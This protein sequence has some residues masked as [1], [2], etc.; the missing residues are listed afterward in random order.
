MLTSRLMEFIETHARSLINA[1]MQDIMTNERTSSFRLVPVSELEPRIAA[2]YL[3]L[4]KWVGSPK[5]EAVQ[6]EYEEWGRTRFHQGIPLSEIVYCIILAKSHLRRFIR[7]HGMIAFSGDR[8]TPDELVP[9]ELYG[10]Q[11]L[12]YMVGEFFDRALY[13]LTRG[14]EAAAKTSRAAV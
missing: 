9:V 4:G 13:H 10:I 7:E 12:N 11:E 2:L 6:K 3:N 8:A 14:Y 5:D 1:V